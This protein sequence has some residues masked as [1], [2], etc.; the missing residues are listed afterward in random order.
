MDSHQFA[1]RANRST[2]DA[3]SF[4][5]HTAL[6]HLEH[7]DSYV[8]MLF[9]TV[10]PYKLVGKLSSLGIDAALCSWIMDFLTN[11]PQNDYTS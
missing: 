3:V 11:R 5:L 8:R 1:Y 9:N 2:D 4:A 6:T 7:P 10:I